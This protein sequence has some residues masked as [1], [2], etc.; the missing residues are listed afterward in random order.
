MINEI[1]IKKIKI[2]N[3]DENEI[4]EINGGDRINET[5]P[6]D[7]IQKT[8]WGK[9]TDVS[10]YLL[11]F[12]TPLFFLPLT[13]APVEINKQVFAALLALVAFAGYLID[14]FG[15]G[16]IAY[17]KSLLSFS[18]AVLLAVFGVSAFL[19]QSKTVSLYGN[20]IQPDSLLSFLI[21]GLIFFLAAVFLINKTDDEKRE[22]IERT[23]RLFFVGL[24]IAA[25]LGLFQIFG[26]KI[27]TFWLIAPLKQIG[28]MGFNTVGSL[29]NWSIYL[30]FGLAMIIAVLFGSDRKKDGRLIGLGILIFFG[31]IVLNYP[32]I[33]M[34][35]A[36]TTLILAAY[37]FA[38]DFKLN[39]GL[40]VIVSL[41]LLLGV[42]GQ[43]LPAILP[44][45][46]ES[47]PSLA[48]TW[49]VAKESLSGLSAVFGNGPAT[50]GY[51][52]AF[53]RPA[54]LNQTNFWPI[55]FNQGFSFLTTAL[56]TV[57]VLGF[58]AVLFLFF[59]F[60]RQS[61][62]EFPASLISEERAARSQEAVVRQVVSL[63][64]IFLFINWLLAPLFFTQSVFIFL[65]LGLI[66][67]LSG[68]VKEISLRNFSRRQNFISFFVLIVLITASLA[69]VFYLGGKHAAAVY[70]E[71]GFAAYNA[72]DLNKALV[73]IDKAV[74]FDSRHDQY[75]RTLSQFLLLRI[76][77]LARQVSGD[78][79]PE[80]QTEIQNTAFLAIES[81]R[82][83][84]VVNP[85]DSLNWSNL[86]GVYEKIIPLAAG[87]DAFAEENYKKAMEL[88]PKNPQE[89]V[90]AARSF[91]VSADLIG[92]KNT[93][94]WREK[95][96]KAKDYLEKSIALKADYAPA[97][98]LSASIYLREGKTKEA[99]EKLEL[100]KAAAPFDSGLAFQLGL[101]YYQN[102][103]P[104]K[105]R[106]EFERAIGI[107]PNYS[108]SR[109]FL[110]LIYDDLGNKQAAL[111]Q[112]EK[113]AELN[114]DNQE[115][116]KIVKNLKTE[117]PALE[118]IVP[119]NQPPAER[120][121]AP[122]SE[123]KNN[124]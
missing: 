85:V 41:F 102:G 54:E 52:Y 77:N 26:G 105:A 49:S 3:E 36:A 93:S 82:R 38:A 104:D 16:K 21:Y 113:I 59:A 63:G 83:A 31:L 45:P 80:I 111:A 22:A 55:R 6:T 103:Q 81:G 75:L 115:I 64:T 123:T 58:L 25:V 24:A 40:L 43:S 4:D 57:G 122:L 17:P 61:R 50:F 74:K 101:V 18:I 121:E 28:L 10:F 19:S 9:I 32:L 119:P 42:V 48:V 47:R 89:P 53:Y 110:G 88:D 84:T 70:Y 69:S 15:K 86:G 20:L 117:R 8:I 44:V 30:A 1:K 72:G 11:V 14:S 33:W 92:S 12:L 120:L 124:E 118:G 98:F 96:N 27:E 39:A 79:P 100:A 5:N 91:I 62:T 51:D 23:G 112:F 95:L 114:P 108:N 94:L 97:H 68:S 78:L 37:K 46:F 35:L 116:K 67:V 109:Y 56:S 60:L 99:I 34:A 65:G 87:A 7:E 73:N 71:N 2:I 107:D 106:F 66:A 29:L 13:I 76:D 90:N